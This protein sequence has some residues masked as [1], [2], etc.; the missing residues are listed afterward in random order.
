V[1]NIG[2]GEMDLRISHRMGRIDDGYK[3]LFGIFSANSQLGLEYGIFDN[4][5]AG[6]ALTSIQYTY[7]GFLKYKILRQCSGGKNIPFTLD[8]Y[9][10]IEDISGEFNYPNNQYY[11]S[12]RLSY[13]HQILIARK[14]N[15]NLS[16]QLTPTFIHKN[17]VETSKD[18]NNIFSIGFSGRCKISK[19]VAL[20]VEYFYVLPDQ[21]ISKLNN[22][23]VTNSLSVGVDVFTGK[24]VFQFFITNS[25]A[26]NE[27]SFITEST[28]KWDKGYLHFGFNISRVFNIVNYYQ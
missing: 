22:L 15:E 18:N 14:F 3:K 12:Q 6:V 19:K 5:M 2:K 13:V 10:S 21:I 9:S 25:V 11:Y 26:M 23:P 24:H 17:I 16:L 1:E 20:T 8:W 7:T 28:E 4:L 27:T